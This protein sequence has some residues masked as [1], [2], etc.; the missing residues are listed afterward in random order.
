MTIKLDGTNGITSTDGTASAPSVTG[1]TST[2]TGLSYGTN[3]VTISTAG[4][5]RATFDASGNLGV[6]TTTPNTYGKLVSVTGD[7]VTTFAAVG[8]T[9]MLRVQGYNS[10]Y[11]GTSLE[12]V[13]LAG[14][15]N[16]PMFIGSSLTK[17]A[18][19]GS[20]QMRLDSSGNVGIGTSSPTQKLDVTGSANVTGTVAM[21]SS[22]M[23]NRLINGNMY[24]DQRNAGAAVTLTNSVF[25]YGVDRWAAY[26]SSATSTV[27]TQRVATS[28]ANFPYVTRIL[29]GSG[30][31]TG[32]TV[33]IQEIETVNCQDLAGQTVTVSFW[34]RKGS[35]ASQ[36][37]FYLQ[38]ISG[39]GTDQGI[40]GANNGTWTAWAAPVI[41]VPILTTTLTQYSYTWSVPAGTNEM[42]LYF[43]VSTYT[44]TGS[45][46]DY[47][48]ITGVQLEVG[49]VATPFERRLYGQELVLCQRY[50]DIQPFTANAQSPFGYNSQPYRVVKRVAPTITTQGTL[51]GATYVDM[52]GTT[53]AAPNGYAVRQNSA[54]STATD[55][56]LFLSAEL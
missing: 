23:R 1:S 25:T 7:N 41:G 42:A 4:S 19:N 53:A 3:T 14:S 43:V 27:T 40:V 10:T 8:A 55:V 24:I 12:A 5:A 50:Y 38:G 56:T 13:N 45:A 16:T 32:S 44:G 35:A 22:F 21:G 26:V 2:N 37:S 17:F 9:N 11:V 15:V 30:T 39:S 34:A 20:E 51:A 29:R 46:N 47:V 6:G 48:D 52:G 49:S 33:F 18:I 36:T 31:F 28:L 54:A